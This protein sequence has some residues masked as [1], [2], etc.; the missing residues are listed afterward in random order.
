MTKEWRVSHSN[1]LY[2]KSYRIGLLILLIFINIGLGW[3]N[4]SYAQTTTLSINLQNKTVKEVFSEIEKK[5]KFSIFYESGSIDLTRKVNVDVKDKT[6]KA[7]MD[8]VIA[9]TNSNYYIDEYQIYIS[10]A[11]K[12]QQQSPVEKG[13][14]VNGTVKDDKGESL[15]GVTIQIKG[16]TTGTLT[17]ID[18]NYFITVPSKETVLVFSYIGFDKQE[19]KVGNQININVNLKETPTGLN[20]VV[21]V[22]FGTQK[23]ASVI[24]SISTVE[25][26]LLQ[27]NSS[28][29]VSNSLSGRIA[30][31]IGVQRSG[32]PGKD[33]S[34]FWIRGIS[35]FQNAGR[36]PLVLVDGVE[37]TLDDLD[38]AEIESFS[39][40]KDAAAS[41]VYG[42]RGAAGV[43]LV[44]TKRGEMGKPRVGVHYEQGFTSP[45]KIPKFV[46]SYDYLSL[47]NEL[48]M[49]AGYDKGDYSDEIL[50]KYKD[51][52]DPDLYPNVN[53]L[54]EVTKDHASN[55]RVNL[56]ISGGSDI[57]RYALVASYYG[58]RGIF[59]RDKRHSWDSS[60]K[61]D[62]YNIRSN[63][64][65]NI[66]KTTLVGIGI[67][68]Y[69]QETNSMETSGDDIFN[70]AFETT[71]F[72]HPTVYSSG[73]FPRMKGR[74]NPWVRATQHGFSQYSAGKIES[75]FS[76][77]QDLKFILP[78]LKIKGLFS[79][80]RYM[81]SGIVR[82]KSPD[83]YNPATS[84]NDDGSL[85]LSIADYGQMF[86]DTERKENWGNKATY[87]E[88]NLSY[89]QRFGKH[90]VDGMFLYN[91]R[92]YK[93][94]DVV[95][96]R[97][98]GVS[99]RA[100]YSFDNRY[101]A[102]LNF[103]YNGSENFES[104]KR[105]GFFPSVAVGYLLSEESFMQNYKET[106]SKI[107]FRASYG[108]VGN[109]QLQG[110]RFAY[111]TTIDS[112]N[113]N[114]YKWGVN[115]DFHRT[116]R[117]EGEFGVPN[118]TWEKVRKTNIG[119]ELGLW[120]A[121]DFQVD[122]FQEHRYDIFMQRNLIP[123]A[124]GFMKTP[125][126]NF[127]KVDNSGIEL[128]LN[129]H[130]ELN[131][132]WML[133]FRGTFTYAANK[134]I[135]QDEAPGVIG[136]NR[137]RTGHAV[138]QLFGLVADG[139]FTEDDFID[140]ENGILKDE[141]PTHS[142]TTKVRPGDIKYVD[143]DGD[144]TITTMD[145]KAI[146]GTWD[147][148]IVYGFGANIAYKNIDVNV[149]FQGTGRTWR[150]IGGTGFMPGS[151]MGSTY[152]IHANYQDRWTPENP[153]Q[154]VFYPRLTYG[155]NENNNKNSTWWLRDMSALRMRDI[156]A[157]YTLPRQLTQKYGVSSL[158]FYVKGT[159]LLTFSKFK[160]W[161]PELD[162]NNGMKYPIM[163]SIS[164]GL[165]INF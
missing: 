71:P 117:Y 111:I 151:T 50:Q 107:K 115:A 103:G 139:L 62:K 126:A 45:V 100:A 80:D 133:G 149:F 86:L 36:S 127:G 105:F 142:F 78:G 121:I 87:A 63:V 47:M 154:D 31:V 26:E 51:G 122:W 38:P 56:T 28:R 118:L 91:Q 59:E 102:E 14:I 24:G 16:E 94:G 152:N 8:Q 11:A 61:L 33:G 30:G 130:K 125:W 39:V 55:Q 54:D 84:R 93:D 146:G 43:I 22:G 119:F 41:A 109:D 99:G 18:G 97:R 92:D 68:G 29:A 134:I 60:T 76:V 70:Q 35:S 128:S 158:R 75:T 157:G 25:P 34:S 131:S 1:P 124:A 64:D 159:N 110:R 123:S 153:S 112:S 135:E 141:I 2:S 15:P 66:T 12:E 137:Q 147:P 140:V 113:D 161:D 65:V 148:Q 32:E 162:T 7:I 27:Q 67:G 114:E 83:Y 138:G 49:D 143:V 9:G 82:K 129:G 81:N 53:W 44:Q 145:E 88:A 85:A 40:L 90:S 57:L 23:K 72:V 89:S 98:M 52:S 104:K 4:N 10:T 160:M 37:R 155:E 73:E 13:I 164:F 21:V 96:Y 48:K 19:I 120:N 17:D 74:S 163:K 108:L 144:G 58:E 95:P 20:E 156:E 42:V 136:T 101:F 46:D 6:V 77:D 5:S 116:G 3:A 106:F 150:F 132:D 79:F 165:D 69:L